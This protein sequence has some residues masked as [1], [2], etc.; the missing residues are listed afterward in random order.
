MHLKGQELILRTAAIG[1]WRGLP[2]VPLD[3]DVLRSRFAGSG[4][5]WPDALA[6]PD[7]KMPDEPTLTWITV[8][9]DRLFA[10]RFAAAD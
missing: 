4:R 8:R 9:G 6:E 2:E 3:R 7:T 1:G 10:A 5:A